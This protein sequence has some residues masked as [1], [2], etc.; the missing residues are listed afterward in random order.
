MCVTLKVN[1]SLLYFLT[2]LTVDELQR[3]QNCAAHTSFTHI[4]GVD[5]YCYLQADAA[6]CRCLS[7]SGS[8]A[9]PNPTNNE[10]I[11]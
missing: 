6:G 4:K 1:M 5:N 9:L 7:A 3:V 2:S 11:I 8:Q 10:G